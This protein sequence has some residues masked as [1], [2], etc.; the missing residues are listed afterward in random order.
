MAQ[1]EAWFDA[2][3]IDLLLTIPPVGGE[4]FTEQTSL[5]G[6]RPARSKLDY[7]A[8]ELEMLLTGGKDGGLFMMIG[9]KRTGQAST[10]EHK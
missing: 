9:R 6:D 3:G 1:V 5:F 4:E 7:V 2:S 8:S 10:D